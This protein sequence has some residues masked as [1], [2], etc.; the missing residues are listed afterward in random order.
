VQPDT[1]SQ[2]TI[3]YLGN[4]DAHELV[5]IDNRGT[6]AFVPLPA[7][8]RRT[9]VTM[10]PGLGLLEMAAELTDSNRGVWSAHS[11]AAAPAWVASTDEVLGQLLAAHWGCELRDP[12]PDHQPDG[13]V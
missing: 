2:P 13:E 1:D 6:R 9:A 3:V 11:S 4:R 5:E 8:K 12:D 10:A 7:G